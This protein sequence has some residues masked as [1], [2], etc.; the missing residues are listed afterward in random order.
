MEILIHVGIDTVQMQGD[1]F[2]CLVRQG[3][4]VRA[5]QKLIGFDREKIRQAGYSD[6]V[7]VMLTNAEELRERK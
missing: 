6:M 5:G 3:E 4:Q 7:V 2:Q 1:G